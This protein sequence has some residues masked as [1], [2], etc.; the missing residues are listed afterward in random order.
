MQAKG[1]EIS[2]Q[3]HCSKRV[4]H[5]VITFQYLKQALAKNQ[6][7]LNYK[8]RRKL[9]VLAMLGTEIQIGSQPVSSKWASWD[10]AKKTKHLLEV[11]P[12]IKL[13][14]NP[15]NLNNENQIKDILP[16]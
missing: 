4:H 13:N 12:L 9:K 8:K 10:T 5:L 7:R 11:K 14:S 15:L 2:S 1:G 6:A 16:L 3:E